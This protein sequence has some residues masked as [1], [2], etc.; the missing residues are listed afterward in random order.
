MQYVS[1]SRMEWRERV[2]ANGDCWNFV[3]LALVTH[4]MPVVGRTVSRFM[5][6]FKLSP[7]IPRQR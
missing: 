7:H 1:F 6:P 5:L 2:F 4:N 3:G